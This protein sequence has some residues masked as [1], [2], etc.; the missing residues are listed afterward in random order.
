MLVICYGMAKSGST[1]A[2]EL[3]RGVLESAGHS[4][5]RIA[6]KAFRK[7]GEGNHMATMAQDALEEAIAEIGSERIVAAKTH[8]VFP[9]VMFPW[10]EEMQ[11]QRKLQVIASYRDPRDICLSL[12]DHGQ[13]S[14]A[15]GERSYAHIGD[16]DRAM[17]LV[18]KAI[19]KFRQWGA[20]EGTLRLFYET[21]AFTPDEA[22]AVIEAALGVKG[23]AEAAK[24]HAFEDAFTQLNKA[25]KNRWETELGD[26]QKAQML[27][28]FGVFIEKVCGRNDQDWFARH[29][30]RLMKRLAAE[31]N[32]AAGG[33]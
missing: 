11:A 24:K 14:R 9:D 21:V 4:Q 26:A 25:R 30:R 19:P 5:A 23:D 6:I 20:V 3:V 15:K 29:R 27:D 13:R 16:L 31:S 8:K 10:I 33:G 12:V 18:E 17:Q 1:L 28:T 7:R 22:I 32:G 2:Y